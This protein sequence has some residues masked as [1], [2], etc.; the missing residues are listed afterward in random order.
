MGHMFALD[1]HRRFPAVF[2]CIAALLAVPPAWGQVSDIG[3]P[4]SLPD[5]TVSALSAKSVLRIAP[6]IA[7]NWYDTSDRN[8]VR[9]AWNLTYLPALSVPTGWNGDVAAGVPRHHHPGL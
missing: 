8:A 6:S 3:D 9:D 2:F 7:G 5:T 4:P 1:H